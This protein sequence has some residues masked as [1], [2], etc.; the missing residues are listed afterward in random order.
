[1]APDN[2]VNLCFLHSPHPYLFFNAAD[3][4]S[5]TFLG[6][7]IDCVSGNVVDPASGEI[8]ERNVM[9]RELQRVLGRYNVPLR[10]NFEQLPR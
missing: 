8:I 5:V 6:L 4:G 2:A 3:H 9:S 7:Y 1:L 10:E